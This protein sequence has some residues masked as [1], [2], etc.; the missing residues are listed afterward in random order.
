MLDYGFA[1]YKRVTVLK[2]GDLLGRTVPVKLGMQDEVEIAA[3]RGMSML[4]KPGQE[5]QLS[6]EIEL[7]DEV[8]APVREG[9]ALGIIRVKLGDGV[10]AKLPAVAHSDVEMPGLLAAFLKLWKNWR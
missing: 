5:K 4:L 6:I 9:D 1:G 3:G 8:Q 10:I 2:R 7:P